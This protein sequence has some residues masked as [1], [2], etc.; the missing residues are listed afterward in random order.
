MLKL[1]ACFLFSLFMLM[2]C[3]NSSNSVSNVKTDSLVTLPFFN[4]PD[5]TPAWINKE[6]SGYKKI[7]SIPSF[8]FKDQ[9]GKDF[10]EAN[11]E[12]KIY[13][14]NFFYTKCRCI[15]P[16]MTTNMSLLQEAFKNDTMILLLSHSVTPELDSITVL[17]NYAILNKV[18][19]KKWH[20]LTGDKNEIYALA[21]QQ[22]FAGDSVG[23]YQTGNEFLHTENFILV[24][25]K[26]RI[27][28]VYNGTLAIEIDR[29]KEDIQTLKLEAVSNE[30]PIK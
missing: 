6:D 19:S 3:N 26:R 2:A 14:A 20:L 21:K 17:K 9:E 29:I 7:H 18:D 27:R 24:D 1:S 4:V 30:G 8:S 11:I 13:V 5:W 15:C 16:K 25:Q 23:F 22:Y 10:T 12:G 28:G